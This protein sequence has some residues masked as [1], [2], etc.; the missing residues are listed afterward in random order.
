[1]KFSIH[2]NRRSQKYSQARKVT[3]RKSRGGK[4]RDIACGFEM[5]ENR[6]MMSGT[7]LPYGI[8]FQS[9]VIR[10]NGSDNA[11]TA[12]VNLVNGKLHATLDHMVYIHVDINTT[13]HFLMHDAVMDFD[14]AVVSKIEFFGNGGDDTF[15]NNTSVK[16]TA[17]GGDGADVLIGGYGDDQLNGG[18]GDDQ[19]E[20]RGGNDS[21][22][23]GAGDDT[24]IFAGVALGSDTITEAASLDTDTLDFTTLG[25]SSGRYIVMLPPG[26][27]TL[28]LSLTS[29]QTVVAGQLSLTLSSSLGIENVIGTAWSDTIRGNA[30]ANVIHGMGGNDILH[31]GDGNDSV[32]GDDGNDVLYQDAGGGFLSGDNGNDQ[33]YA[34]ALATSLSGGA[35][36]D[37]LVSIGGSHADTCTGGAGLDS[38][39]L[40]KEATEKLTDVAADE[41]SKGHVHRVAAFSTNKIVNGNVTTSQTPSRD[42][43]GQNLVDPLNAYGSSKSNFSADPLFAPTGPGVNDIIQGSVGDCYFVSA[44][45]AFAK[46]NPDKVRQ[47]VVDLGDGTYAVNFHKAGQDVFVRVDADLYGAGTS[48]VYAGLGAQNSLWVAII[49]KAYALFKNQQ[50][51]YASIDGGNGAGVPLEEALNAPKGSFPTTDY[52]NATDFLSA[53]R[54]QLLAGKAVTVGGPAPFLPGTVKSKTDNPN[55]SDDE[56]TFHRGAHIYTLISVSADLKAITLRNPWG[57]D[58]G[59]NDANPNDGYVT[60]PADLA[61]FC[62][63]GFAAYTV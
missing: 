32:Y 54:Q 13:T 59:G 8:S 43:L 7:P 14:P 17:V 62:S 52:A 53:M 9:G 60:I 50:G 16:T 63:G 1:M 29:K 33:L 27:A 42:R 36:D 37:T 61:F 28:D 38:F 3:Q 22:T 39:W 11:E 45:A 25:Q 26:G 20:G 47:L 57:Y 18:A 46:T 4:K 21:L 41:T 10:I 30:R 56:D 5:L 48:L 23:G 31:G 44:L 58:G 40:D 55:T 12:A 51:T 34:G 6:C 49:E 19:I 35:G 15:T 24:Y 2:N